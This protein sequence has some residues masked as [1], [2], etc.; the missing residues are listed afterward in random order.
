[1]RLLLDHDKR[2]GLGMKLKLKKRLKIIIVIFFIIISFI[3]IGVV[4][5]NNIKPDKEKAVVEK[6]KVQDFNKLTVVSSRI[7]KF[8]T[9]NSIYVKVKN[10]TDKT[11]EN[12]SLIL[13]IYDKD[14]NVL[15]VSNIENVKK[16]EVGD[17]VEF[18][19]STNKDLSKAKKYVVEKNNK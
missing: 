9:L 12:G 10:N 16:L 14:D 2:K 8:G 5:I 15:L 18:Q 19:V 6:I 17:E 4:V 11:I 3:I 1:M 13:T 7:E